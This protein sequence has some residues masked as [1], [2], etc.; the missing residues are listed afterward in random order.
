MCM[1][2]RLSKFSKSA[3][4]AL[5]LLAACG[6]TYS[7]S[8]EYDLDETYPGWLNKS[9]YGYLQDKGSYTNYVQLIEDLKLKEVLSQT[10][11]KTLFVANDEAF[12]RFYAENAKRSERDPW[13]TATAYDKLTEAQKKIILH[14]SMINNAYLLEMMSS[15]QGP[16]KGECLRRENANEITDTIPFFFGTELPY[17]NNSKDKDYWAGFRKNGIN[18]VLD[19]TPAMM[20]HFLSAQMSEKNITDEDFRIITGQTRTK[21]DAHIFGARVIEQ[22]QTCQNGYVNMLDRVLLP[23]VNMAEMIRTNGK[24]NLFSHMLDRFSAPYYNS[25]VTNNYKLLYPEF[26][27]SIFEKRYFSEVSHPATPSMGYPVPY[28]QAG[29][30]VKTGPDGNVPES[31]PSLLFDPGWN[32]YTLSGFSKEA[33]MGAIFVPTDEVIKEYFLPGG[34]GSDLIRNYGDRENTESNLIHNMDQ[35]PMS[36]L[37][38][39]LNNLMKKSFLGSVPSKFPTVMDDANDN[40]FT[41]DDVQQI[42]TVLLASNG[43]VYLMKKVYTPADYAS[44]A[45]PAYISNYM[46]IFKW[47]VYNGSKTGETDYIQ[48]NF[49]AY[50]KAM[51]SRFTFFVPTDKALSIYVD[52]ASLASRQP[53]VLCFSYNGKAFP[54]T[55]TVRGYDVKTGAIGDTIKSA[56][57]G[58][59]VIANRLKDMLESHTIVHENATE[60]QLG[61]ES[62]NEFYLTKNGAAIKVQNP[63]KREKGAMV[64]GGFQLESKAKGYTDTL[65]TECKVSEYFKKDNGWTY[66]IN[67]PITNATQSVYTILKNNN[68]ENSPYKRFYDLM[69]YAYDDIL[70]DLQFVDITMTQAEQERVLNTYRIFSDQKGLDYNV[71]FFNNYRYTIYVP[72]N[73]AVDKAITEHGLPS[74]ESIQQYINDAKENNPNDGLT[75]EQIEVGKAMVT[76]L[77]NFIKYHFQDNSVFA[78]KLGFGRTTYETSTIDRT[79]NRYLTVSI[80]SEGEK[81]GVRTL[82]V[83]DQNNKTRKVFGNIN[84]MA[85]DL[86]CSGVTTGTT[87]PNISSSSF[88]VIHQIDGALSFTKLPVVDGKETYKSL[89]NTAA[90]AKRFVAKYRIMK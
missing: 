90:K 5:C 64:Y 1:K 7:C 48:Q 60:R 33:D 10:G 23:P 55:C 38:A 36:V 72:T 77:L 58:T 84:M 22:D 62:G 6:M 78:D 31:S 75:E 85:R 76:C 20:T 30:Y 74:W 59:D 18:M 26:N 47:A 43:A 3:V 80:S 16:V 28:S 69:T 89:F 35:I 81:N 24:T 87:A 12:A 51:N 14:S 61:I 65:L 37:Q 11:S 66:V 13:H 63:E 41:M 9:I 57:I 88:A 70:K 42:D 83:T 67:E 71:N 19:N 49:Y 29:T 45:A 56:T 52:P 40:M 73:E 39:L 86:E 21:E 4:R 8:D 46:Q 27:D 25:R 50:L 44:V 2:N 53:R 68:D 54:I 32:E 17:S 34:E 15:T 82:S 79:T